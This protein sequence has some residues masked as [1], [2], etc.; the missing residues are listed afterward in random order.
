MVA[1]T[2]SVWRVTAKHSC[3]MENEKT[4]SIECQPEGLNDAGWTTCQLPDPEIEVWGR[5]KEG[6]GESKGYAKSGMAT[7]DAAELLCIQA[8]SRPA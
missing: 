5:E 8:C 6:W 7:P 3:S 2:P 4:K 1:V